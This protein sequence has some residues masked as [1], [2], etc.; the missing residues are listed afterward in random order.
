MSARGLTA[1]EAEA[2]LRESGPN[3]PAPRKAR[4]G[5]VEIALYLANPLVVI[6]LLAAVVSA[7][8][9]EVVNAALVTV[10]VVVSIVVSFVQTYRS[11]RAADR[12]REGV[13][14]TATVMRDGAW[15]EV[16]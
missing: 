8:L 10:M 12:L 4:S 11:K 16:R 9:G 6:L 5:V 3:D 7:V 13:A 1:R 14:P 15:C 2:R